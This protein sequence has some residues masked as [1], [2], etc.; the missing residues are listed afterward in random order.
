MTDPSCSGTLIVSPSLYPTLIASRFR[1]RCGSSEGILLHRNIQR[2]NNLP[3]PS[4]LRLLVIS[5][6]LACQ[7]PRLHDD[8]G[9]FLP[10]RRSPE[11]GPEFLAEPR[12][13]VARR[14]RRRVSPVEHGGVEAGIAQLR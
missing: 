6:P 1:Q 2:L 10:H 7:I 4:K 8:R 3:P 13:D 14:P 9:E 12:D 5:K 11:H